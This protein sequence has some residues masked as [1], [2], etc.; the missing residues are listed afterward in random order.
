MVSIFDLS[1]KLKKN[2]PKGNFWSLQSILHSHFNKKRYQLGWHYHCDELLSP[3]WIQS[4]TNISPS[5]PFCLQ[6]F[7][8]NATIKYF[9]VG[10]GVFIHNITRKV[11]TKISAID[12]IL[13][14]ICRCSWVSWISSVCF[15]HI[16]LLFF[17]LLEDILWEAI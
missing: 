3:T 4:I 16:S 9:D 17:K 6:L 7:S 10:D 14:I 5:T 1:W 12:I 2:I 15:K 11:V 13:Y 8:V